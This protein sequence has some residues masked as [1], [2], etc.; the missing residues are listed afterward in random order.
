MAT[1][2]APFKCAGIDDGGGGVPVRIGQPQGALMRV[3]RLSGLSIASGETPA[4]WEV[5]VV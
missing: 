2:L 3:S 1:V 5:N 4:H